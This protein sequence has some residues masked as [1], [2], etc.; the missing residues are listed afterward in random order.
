M[1]YCK[2]NLFSIFLIIVAV[3]IVVSIGGSIFRA[4]KQSDVYEGFSNSEIP[5]IFVVRPADPNWQTRIDNNDQTMDVASTNGWSADGQFAEGSNSGPN[6]IGNQFNYFAQHWLSVTGLTSGQTNVWSNNYG[7]FQNYG[8]YSFSVTTSGGTNN[9]TGIFNPPGYTYTKWNWSAPAPPPP[10]PT[11]N[12][13]LNIQELDNIDCV[14]SQIPYP[15]ATNP[16]TGSSNYTYLGN[17]ASYNDCVNNA[18]IGPDA[19]AIT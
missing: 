6:Q 7:S 11:P 13:N 1:K 12:Q 10:T 3:I 15:G 2:S 9:Y 19:K 18:T 14:Y 5:S 8:P 16:G 17:F 4:V